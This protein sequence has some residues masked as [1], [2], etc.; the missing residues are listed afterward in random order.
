MNPREEIMN[1]PESLAILKDALEKGVV[2]DGFT[3]VDDNIILVDDEDVKVFDDPIRRRSSSVGLGLA[4]AMAQ[5]AYIPYIDD[6]VLSDG[7]RTKKINIYRKY[8]PNPDAQP[9]NERC[10]CGSG[11]KHKYC[12]I[13]K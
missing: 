1:N 8:K 12:C 4:T 10:K 13:K 11:K 2:I 3:L 5:M 7:P 9:R 6:I